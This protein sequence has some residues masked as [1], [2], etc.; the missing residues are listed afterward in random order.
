MEKG[1]KYYQETSK[2]I[3]CLLCRHYCNLA[4]GQTGI[5]GVNK[6]EGGALKNLVYGKVAAINIDPIEKKPLYHFL[7]GS[8]ALSIGTVGCNLKCPFCQN[9]QIS[10]TGNL[11]FS[12]EA[13][14]EQIVYMAIERDCKTIAYTYNE[15]TVFYP[16][17]RDTA[18]LAKQYGLRNIFVSN[19]MESPEVIDDMKGII[20]AFNIDLKSFNP[21]FYKKTL[22]GSLEG[23]LDTLKR[24]RE[25][26]FWLE[27]TTLVVPDENDSD[28]ELNK[29]ASFIAN[30]LGT[31]T[32][33]HIS[34]F[35]PTYKMT[36]K[37]RT[38]FT[39][40]QRAHDIGKKNGLQYIYK[41]NVSEPGTTVCPEC[42]R[43][44]I[45]RHGYNLSKNVI[46]GGKCPYC[47][48]KIEGVWK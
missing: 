46:D 20:D 48:T 8:S 36:G 22:K 5:C 6:N 47:N 35:Y 44:L 17:A 29:I 9:W 31:F 15:P 16:F 37:S 32:P 30:E 27:V 23:V 28:E 45:V 41:G 2:G 12:E 10:Q 18:L 13:T 38:S 1:M 24:I 26:G 7:P 11:N 42:G 34:A 21:D 3:K 39:V 25:A 14:P 19:G 43:E 33:W 40:L 4:E